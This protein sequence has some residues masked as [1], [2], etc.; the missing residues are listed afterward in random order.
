MDWHIKLL[1]ATHKQREIL[2]RD[3]NLQEVLLN[4]CIASTLAEKEM[5]MHGP[6]RKALLAQAHIGC[7]DMS[8]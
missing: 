6:F 3:K 5:N 8:C 4:D 7:L 2:R 1:T